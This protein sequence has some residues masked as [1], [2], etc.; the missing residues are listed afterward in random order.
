MEVVDI[1]KEAIGIA[2]KVAIVIHDAMGTRQELQE[3]HADIRALES[4]L[5]LCQG[6]VE[7]DA[8]LAEAVVTLAED[9]NAAVAALKKTIQPYEKAVGAKKLSI[10]RWKLLFKYLDQD[11]IKR[12][13]ERLRHYAVLINGVCG[14]VSPCQLRTSAPRQ[15][16]TRGFRIKTSRTV[17]DIA[18]TLKGVDASLNRLATPMQE[19]EIRLFKKLVEDQDEKTEAIVTTLEKLCKR[20]ADTPQ[21]DRGHL[22]DFPARPGLSKSESSTRRALTKSR[23]TPGGIP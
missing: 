12:Y 13:Q 21:T 7:G 9:A 14:S 17:T 2:I 10:D 4:A 1:V 18:T 16:L 5:K 3:L 11:D 6:L 8:K 20:M 22:T 23:A 19:S 15:R